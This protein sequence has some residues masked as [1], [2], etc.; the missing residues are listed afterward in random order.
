MNNKF[1]FIESE[2]LN[3]E[4]NNLIRTQ[5]KFSTA[6]QVKSIINGKE[7]TL[8][9]SSNYL[10]MAEDKEIFK[11]A[12]EMTL[13]F[14]VGSG[15]SRLTTG[16]TTIHEA[17]EDK[18]SE[19][20]N[21]ESTI[22]F[23]SGYSANVGVI[24]AI[25]SKNSIIFSDEKN[26]ASIIDG[27]RLSGSKIVVYKHNDMIDLENKL[28]EY[29]EEKKIIVSD[30]VFSMDADILKLDEF[31]NL[32]NKY[33][34]ISVVDDAHGFGVLGENGKGIIEHFNNEFYPDI[35]IAT[36]SKAIGSEGGFASTNSKIKK[37]LMHKARSYVFSTSLSPFIVAFSYC[38]INSLMKSNERV[39][40]L[41]E[42]IAYL[43]NELNKMG[44]E[45]DTKTPIIK[46]L[47]GDEKKA[48]EIS[49]KLNEAGIYIPAIRFPTVEKKKA[50]L[51]ITLMSNH[52]KEDIDNLIR[53]L[54]NI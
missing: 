1:D 48:M 20:I 34:A 2:L 10:S 14:G 44:I 37:F 54:K 47:I 39:K 12:Y 25:A 40:K 35:L 11:E 41:K 26:H 29:S 43:V 51:R 5:N 3:L 30:G 24:S 22:L 45:I 21:Y 27:C 18:I 15:G 17:L 28:K 49:A 32:G 4:R 46:I 23:S 8:F 6:Q 19:F 36:L 9:S 31:V 42:N 7:M 38:V 52:S 50:I 13:E 53:N 16:N 33:K